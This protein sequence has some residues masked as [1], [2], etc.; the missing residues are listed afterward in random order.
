MDNTN[1]STEDIVDT[2]VEYI[3]DSDASGIFSDVAAGLKKG[4]IVCLFTKI[5]IAK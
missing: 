4:T 5:G 2:I 3:A 1:L